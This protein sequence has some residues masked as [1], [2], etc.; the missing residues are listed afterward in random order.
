VAHT[1][2]RIDVKAMA[3]TFPLREALNATISSGRLEDTKVILYSRRDP[4]GTICQPRALYASSHV[5]RTVPYF[6]D[7]MPLQLFS[8]DPTNNA[9]RVLFGTFAEA[10]SKDFSEPLDDNEC[11]EG[12]GYHPD[13]DLEE[14]DDAVNP[15]ETLNRTIPHTFDPFRSPLSDNKPTLTDGER[16]KWVEK[17]KVIKIHDVAFIT[18]VCSKIHHRTTKDSIDSKPFCSISTPGTSSLRRMDRRRTAS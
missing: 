17:G 9:F 16:G 13:S 2:L 10:E 7:R 11:A 3:A 1:H 5:L 6:N 14:E 15:K 12:Y 4:F 18:C 8:S